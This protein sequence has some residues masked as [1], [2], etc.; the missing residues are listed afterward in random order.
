MRIASRLSSGDPT[1][2]LCQSTVGNSHDNAREIL[3]QL[4]LLYNCLKLPSMGLKAIFPNSDPAS[5]EGCV[6][7]FLSTFWFY[8][9]PESLCNSEFRDPKLI[10]RRRSRPEI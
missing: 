10:G 3:A 6:K 9:F 7:Y 8:Y 1:G 2:R 4:P 5:T